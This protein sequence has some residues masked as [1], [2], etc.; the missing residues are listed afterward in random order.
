M[1][2]D[3]KTLTGPDG[4]APCKV[5]FA[6]DLVGRAMFGADAAGV[7][8]LWRDGRIR[9]AVSRALLARYLR[10]LR[11]LGL[12]ERLLRRWAWWFS[13]AAWVHYTAGDPDESLPLADLC[14]QVARQNAAEYILHG[15]LVMSAPGALPWLAAAEFLRL[16]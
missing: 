8:E 15:G 6:P 2:S 5:V 10:V 4:V 3:L 16:T 1:K 12:E 9:P 7:F 13:S 14:L 11:A